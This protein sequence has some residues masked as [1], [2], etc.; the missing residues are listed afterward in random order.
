MT[1]EIILDVAIGLS[2]L[3]FLTSIIASSINEIFAAIFNSRGRHLERAIYD[4]LDGAQTGRRPRTTDAFSRR[5]AIDLP[6][7]IQAGSIGDEFFS[8]PL[9]KTFSSNGRLPSFIDDDIAGEAIRRVI[10]KNVSASGSAPSNGTPEKGILSATAYTPEILNRN[11]QAVAER[12]YRHHM[13]RM[14]GWYKRRT[15]ISLFFI[16]LLLAISLD[17]NAIEVTARLAK[18]A[19][20][21]ERVA[22]SATAY[23][24]SQNTGRTD[25][26]AKQRFDNAFEELEKL[27]LPIGH[28]F[29]CKS[30]A[31]ESEK[32]KRSSKKIA[33]RHLEK[34]S[35]Q[36]LTQANRKALNRHATK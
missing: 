24:A 2:L 12:L 11:G 17:L 13:D 25:E 19:N 21:R 34:N 31:A 7:R 30:D 10:A 23:E 15:Q 9:I 8:D 4:L 16:G 29:L 14:S 35:V 28:G 1:F 20:L 5:P 3:F 27:C 18:D 6:N 26:N 33:K 32:R 36:K 22:A